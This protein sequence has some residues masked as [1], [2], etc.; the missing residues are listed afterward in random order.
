MKNLFKNMKKNCK[1]VF[2]SKRK[3]FDTKKKR[4]IDS[5]HAMI[6][7]HAEVEEKQKSKL[8]SDAKL[9]K[10]SKWKK[11]SEELRNI[12]KLNT[13]DTKFNMPNNKNMKGKNVVPSNYGGSSSND[14]LTHCNIC[15][16]R[17]NEDAY[18]KHLNFCQKRSKD[19]EMKAKNKNNNNSKQTN[20]KYKK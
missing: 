7:K 9:K 15:N 18:K 16:R 4:I 8:K 13:T 10:K 12:A 11:Q 17:Y 20:S 5:E 19:N 2:Q 14:D 3:T 6:L 1:K